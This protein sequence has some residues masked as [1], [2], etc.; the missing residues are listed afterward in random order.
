VAG[1]PDYTNLDIRVSPST[2]R[3]VFHQVVGNDADAVGGLLGDVMNQLSDILTTMKNLQL[4]W[5]GD[6]SS[7]AQDLVDQLNHACDRLFGT[8]AA[9][10][11]GVFPRILA[12]LAAAEG[13]YAGAEDVVKQML[14][15]FTSGSDA[16]GG[17]GSS[18]HHNVDNSGGSVITAITETY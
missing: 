7:Q 6:A 12:G 14:S 10:K 2:I 8:Q 4:S 17:S 1:E 5:F 9:P 11:G 3:D 13:N 18:D 16:S 15:G